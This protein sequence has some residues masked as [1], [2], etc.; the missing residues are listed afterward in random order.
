M[1]RPQIA[2]PE[3]KREVSVEEALSLYHQGYK[4]LAT[5]SDELG[6]YGAHVFSL[7]WDNLDMNNYAFRQFRECGVWYVLEDEEGISYTHS[8]E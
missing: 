7:K 3:Q 8:K 5:V 1:K 6:I 2:V 4:V